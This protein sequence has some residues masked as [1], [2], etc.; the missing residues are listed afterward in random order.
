MGTLSGEVEG[1]VC[2]VEWIVCQEGHGYFVR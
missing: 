1:V 2:Q